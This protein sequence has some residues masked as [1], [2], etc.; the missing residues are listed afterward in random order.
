MHI[1]IQTQILNKQKLKLHKNI[2]SN[3]TLKLKIITI[4]YDIKFMVF[5]NLFIHS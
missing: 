4:L 3:F 5:V 1:K 2:L